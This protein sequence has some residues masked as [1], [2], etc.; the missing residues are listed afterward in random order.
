MQGEYAVLRPLDGVDGQRRPT[1]RSALM[2]PIPS[3]GRRR[4]RAGRGQ[5]VEAP[6]FVVLRIREHH[7]IIGA[8]RP[9]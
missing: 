4:R 2:V 8:C 5:A 6:R 9:R 7:Q 1:K 3:I